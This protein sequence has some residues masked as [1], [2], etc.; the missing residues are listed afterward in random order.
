MELINTGAA[1]VDIGAWVVKDSGEGNNTA[2]Q[3]GVV[4]A[5]GG[6]YVVNMSGLGAADSARLFD[7]SG[8][9]VLIDTVSWAAHASTTL[10]RCPETAA[11]VLTDN[12]VGTKWLANTC[13][14]AATWP[15]GAAVSRGL[16]QHLRWR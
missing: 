9:P 13:S 16:G 10:S 11:G 6:R 15:G 5:P 12:Q 3:I 14:P 2:V 8:V 4:L 7:D 1:P